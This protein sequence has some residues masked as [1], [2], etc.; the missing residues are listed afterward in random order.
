MTGDLDGAMAA[1]QQA[2]ELAAALGDSVLQGR[3]SL[4]T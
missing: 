4:I 2:L 3:A 1:G